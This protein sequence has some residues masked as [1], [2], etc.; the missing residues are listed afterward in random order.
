[1]TRVV[2]PYIFWC[3]KAFPYLFAPVTVP[4]DVRFK[5]LH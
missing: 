1:M 3:G 5:R 2:V 4:E